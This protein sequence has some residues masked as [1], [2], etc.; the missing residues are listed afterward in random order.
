MTKR[1]YFDDMAREIR[2]VWFKDHKA[3]LITDTPDVKV[4]GWQAPGTWIYGMRFILH[5]RWLTVLGDLGEAVFEWSSDLDL[6][7]LS[8]LN[9]GYFA[10]K[11]RASESG[12]EFTTFD[13]D[14][15]KTELEQ[16][17]KE[18]NEED[19]ERLTEMRDSVGSDCDKDEWRQEIREAYENGLLADSEEASIVCSLG[20]VPD[21]HAIAHWV[22]IK[23]AAKQLLNP[24]VA[25]PR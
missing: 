8:T 5:R 16:Y 21:G 17:I 23:M 20:E 25:C 15:L 11:C 18:A 7:F 24:E 12:R 9:F 14:V 3:T 6:E 13:A 2:E 19:R 1:E 22:G 4:I 10:G